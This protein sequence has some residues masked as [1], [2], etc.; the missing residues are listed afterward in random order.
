MF[1][2]FEQSK[3]EIARLV[4]HS[5]THQSLYR[6]ITIEKRSDLH[7][8]KAAAGEAE[9]ER[10]HSLIDDTSAQTRSVR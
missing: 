8:R 6:A 1:I 3:G 10:L 7:K 5:L 9:R 4:R 2:T